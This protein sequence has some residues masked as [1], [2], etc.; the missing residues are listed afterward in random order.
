MK[1]LDNF[2]FGFL[3]IG[4]FPLIY[5]ISFVL[6]PLAFF[7]LPYNAICMSFY[8]IPL[9][10]LFFVWSKQK[11]PSEIRIGNKFLLSVMN[12]SLQKVYSLNADSDCTDFSFRF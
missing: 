3:Y 2:C 6:I 1:T 11:L 5:H 10:R 7:T 4:S 12:Y 9:L 8:S